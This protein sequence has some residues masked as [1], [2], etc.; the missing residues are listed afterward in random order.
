MRSPQQ[1]TNT[2]LKPNLLNHSNDRTPYVD[3]EEVA[4]WVRTLPHEER[5]RQEGIDERELGCHKKS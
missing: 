4:T 3:V 2:R 1:V 5:F